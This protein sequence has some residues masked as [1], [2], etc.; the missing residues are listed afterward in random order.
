LQLDHLTSST[1]LRPIFCGQELDMFLDQV[2]RG[3]ASCLRYFL[4]RAD[5][6]RPPLPG[7]LDVETAG[8][9]DEWFHLLEEVGHCQRSVNGRGIIEIERKIDSVLVQFLHLDGTVI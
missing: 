6:F 9:D 1:Q 4:A 5:V 7:C 2:K 8:S 3:R